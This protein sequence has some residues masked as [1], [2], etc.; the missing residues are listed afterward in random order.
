MKELF[1]TLADGT[2]VHRWSLENGGTRLKVLSYGGAVQSLELPD[3]HGRYANVSLGLGT[4]EEY[5][6]SSPYFGAVIGRYGNRIAG[7]RFTL[8]GEDHQL[9]VNDGGN[10]LHGGPDGFDKHVWAVEEFTSGSDVG[11]VLRR[12]SPDGEM[13]YP[14]TLTTK[15]TYTLTGNG[16]WRIDYEATTDRATVVNLTNHVYWNLAG[17]S[18][19]SVHDH[20]LAVAAS[21]FTPVDASLVPTGELAEVAGTAFDFRTPKT[22]GEDLGRPDRQLLHTKGFDHNLVLDKGLTE[23]P[24]H[25]A[26][27]R[28]PVSG[29]ILSIATTEPGVQFY[30]GNFLDGA[31]VGPGGRAYGPGSA[32]CL[33]TQHFPDSPNRPEFPSTV[34][35]PGETY[36]STTVHSFDL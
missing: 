2:K 19:G 27:L 18:G 32:L 6:A 16:D 7:G 17:E 4:I 5:E 26:T 25:F 1:G 22:V 12:T 30:S 34:L 9:P 28:E 20:E 8:D 3:R 11:L 13:G 21:R 31:L 14:G 24:E 36:R 23:Q 35:R 33:E 15:V 10:N 29:R